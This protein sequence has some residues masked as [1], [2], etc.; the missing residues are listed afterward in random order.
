MAKMK[1]LLSLLLLVFG[2][3]TLN[4]QVPGL[5]TGESPVEWIGK[6]EK[7]SDDSF[8][9]IFEAKIKENWHIFSQHT[10]DGGS[11]PLEIDYLSE[12]NYKLN[13]ETE[14]SPTK[15][16]FNDVFD[17]D[18]IIWENQAILTQN[19]TPEKD[20]LRYVKAEVF[21]QVCDEVCI[22]EDYYFVFD[23]KEEEGKIF[24]N[25]DEFE[26]FGEEENATETEDLENSAQAETA[27]MG[28]MTED[29]E[30]PVDWTGEVKENSEDV[31]E[32]V[33][34]AKIKENWH[35]FSQHTPDG[36]SLPLEIDYLEDGETYK[37]EGETE[38]S[39]TKTQFNDVFGV[40]EIIWENEATL[41][42]KIKKT[43]ADTRFIKAEV[44]Y[45]VCDEVCINE[46]YYFVFDLEEKTAEIFDNY[47][48]FEAF[49]ENADTENAS[50]TT[51][52]SEK[53]E[54]NSSDRG[55]WTTFILAFLW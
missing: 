25:Y 52:D 14:E 24:D 41:T 19:I 43:D 37:T 31:Y 48:D 6:V 33:F 12:E 53:S 54:S 17:V 9:L 38:E 1:N 8:D 26:A 13:G 22:N 16:Q 3:L 46:E 55:L 39:A 32:L 49:G 23:L 40:D 51:A 15:T 50:S 11:L 42:Q 30:S 35:I 27:M 36:G 20:D 5:E 18:E 45:Q 29:M 44:F 28:G 4:A 47:D 34:H 2:V 7:K 10:P 21:Y